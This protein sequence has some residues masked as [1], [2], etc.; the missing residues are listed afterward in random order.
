LE[1]VLVEL[2]FIFPAFLVDTIPI[3]ETARRRPQGFEAVLVEEAEQWL[4]ID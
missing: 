1:T 2:G 3:N 4:H